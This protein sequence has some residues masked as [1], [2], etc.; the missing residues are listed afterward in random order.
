MLW[1]RTK[2]Y[3]VE[4]AILHWKVELQIVNKAVL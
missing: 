1:I 3:V 2:T 4:S